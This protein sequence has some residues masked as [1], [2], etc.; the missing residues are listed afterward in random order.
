MIGYYIS[1][2]YISRL[3][4]QN[5]HYIATLCYRL[6]QLTSDRLPDAALCQ[7]DPSSSSSASLDAALAS[8]E[9]SQTDP[10][11]SWNMSATFRDR[12]S[13]LVSGSETLLSTLHKG[14]YPKS[15]LLLSSEEDKIIITWRSW[16]HNFFRKNEPTQYIRTFLLNCRKCVNSYDVIITNIFVSLIYHAP[17]V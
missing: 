10:P 5:V 9:G 11:T 8:P 1:I 15:P 14:M 16:I 3:R 12:A 4:F 2:F 6:Q 7:Q 17:G 13:A